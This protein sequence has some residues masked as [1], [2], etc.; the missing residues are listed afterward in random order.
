MAAWPPFL[1]DTDPVLRAVHALFAALEREE[2]EGARTGQRADSR[3][4]V[5]SPNQLREA[6]SSL[7]GELFK[8]GEFWGWLVA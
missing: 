2:A 8:V 1:R 6:L 5:V 7:P 3:H 4:S